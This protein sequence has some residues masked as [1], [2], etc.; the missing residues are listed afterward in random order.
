MPKD[1]VKSRGFSGEDVQ[2]PR[3][4]KK[5]DWDDDLAGAEDSVKSLT[6]AEMEALL[7]GALLKPSRVTV[8]RLLML[9][10]MVMM[11]SAAAWS[12]TGKS[13]NLDPAVV[14]AIF[15][16]L[17]AL[18]PSALFAIRARFLVGRSGAI[19]STVFALVTGELLK[20]IATVA[21]FVLVIVFYPNLEWL[22]LLLTYVI[23]LKCYLLALLFK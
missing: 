18:V 19:G 20:I 23:T 21:I 13:L 7:G 8:K 5:D 12:A 4:V 11:V 14:S 9:Q 6:K 1:S 15:G 17:A 22:P 10:G 16:G 3:V 2:A